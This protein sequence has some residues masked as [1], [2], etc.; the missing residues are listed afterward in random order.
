MGNRLILG[1]PILIVSLGMGALFALP[2]LMASIQVSEPAPSCRPV[3]TTN[4]KKADVIV[5]GRVEAVLQSGKTA[6]VW[7]EP[8]VW[9]KGKSTVNYLH[10]QATIASG[11]SATSGDL[12]FA[13]DQPNYLLFLRA[14]GNG[15]Y[16]TSKCYG[17]R[18][19]GD[20][21]TTAEAQA[22]SAQK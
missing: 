2:V 4:I 19:L 15:R 12:H 18:L 13:S 20:G 14:I 16:R 6:D 8:V 5:N 21:L 9:Y 7:I 17:S 1:V 22:L 11:S 3:L 10:I